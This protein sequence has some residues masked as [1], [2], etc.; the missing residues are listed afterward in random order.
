MEFKKLALEYSTFTSDLKCEIEKI[1]ENNC[2]KEDSPAKDLYR[3]LYEF[4]TVSSSRETTTGQQ[5][6][7]KRKKRR[8]ETYM[9]RDMV[10][11]LAVC[12]NVTPVINNE[13]E[14]E[15]QASSPDEVALVKFVESLGYKLEKR[16]Q[17]TITIKNK[18]DQTEEYEILDCFPFSSDTKRMGITVKY[19]KNGL[20]LFYCK[21][22][23]VV[24]KD[25]VKPQQRSYLLEK[26]EGLAMEGLRTL[27]IGQK[28]MTHEEY[29]VWSNKYKKAL[30]DYERGDF[31][32][33]Q[34]RNEL[35][36]NLEC[37]GITGVEDKLQDDVEKTI[38][39]LRGAGIQI[40]M[41]TGDKVETATCISISTGLKNR[42]QRHYFMKEMH[43][44]NEVDY[45]LKELER[46][47]TNSCLMI[48]GGTLDI[49]MSNKRIEQMFFDI[50]CRAPVVC[51]C[52]CSPTQ[53]AIITQKV[54][55]Y[56]GKRVACVGDGGN[57]VGMILESNVGIGIV[58]KE[59]K[60]ASLAGDFSIN[61]FSYLKR[62]ILWHG[63][64][65]YKRSALLSQFVIHRG[66]IISVI[67][68]VF[69]IIF[70][71]V[72]I[73]IYNGYLMLGYATVYTSMPVFSIVL[74]K[75]TGVQQAL[76]Y[77]PLY[78]TLQKGRSLSFKTFL[79]WV[80]KSIFQGGLIM[81]SCITF[82][83]DSFANIVTITFSALIIVE[84]LNVYSVV[85][86]FNWK[87]AIASLF[88]LAIYIISIYSFREY[89]STSYIDGTFLWKIVVLAFA[90]WA[91][92]HLAKVIVDC[93]D[94]PEQKKILSGKYYQ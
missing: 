13:G 35:E 16:D 10:T 22:A 48:D 92:L 90:S 38:G 29:D 79:I 17:K 86:K 25:R 71:F 32:A 83:N 47:V 4:E 34:V 56:T 67:Q 66:L 36:A 8:D 70:Y 15:L 39:S 77:P 61:Q 3:S 43:S 55:K 52:R 12:H 63:R 75:D 60:Q 41:L 59:G 1:V 58:G 53:K 46:N 2:R 21:G 68:A 74:D 84:L 44:M 40:W 6:S 93:V 5:N 18:I 64:Q 72:S 23:E 11:A 89:F 37:L 14:R 88:T 91:P 49:C 94:P 81:F 30:N 82:F 62:L 80:W 76:D 65:S 45:K 19:K 85:N 87:M 31:L 73:P 57:D 42:S 9:I 69:S 20:I 24:M 54:I 26:C 7:L 27:V 51:V 50:A 28:V 78:K 33:E